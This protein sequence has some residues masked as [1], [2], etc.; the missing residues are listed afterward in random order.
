[1]VPPTFP[2]MV[3]VARRAGETQGLGNV[4]YRVLDAERMDLR[5]HVEGCRWGYMLM[6][7]PGAALEE[8]RRVLRDGGRLAFAVWQTPDRNP[9]AAVP[10]MTLV[11]RHMPRPDRR[12]A[13]HLRAR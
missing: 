12:Y 2:E 5:R 11:Q 4:E 13:G 7:D 8:T 9:W 1:M 6:A 10:G 3:D